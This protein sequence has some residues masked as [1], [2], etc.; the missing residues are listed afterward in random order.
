MSNEITNYIEKFGEYLKEG[1]VY[2]RKAC[3]LYVKAIDVDPSIIDKFKE[4]YDLTDTAW[5][6]FEQVGRGLLHEKLLTDYSLGARKLKML[7]FS[8]QARYSASPIEY[9]TKDNDVLKIQL[10]N[11]TRNQIKQVFADDHVRSIA[12]QRAFIECLKEDNIIPIS[13]APY[14]IKNAKLIVKEKDISFSL[15]QL[16]KIIEDMER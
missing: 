16:K 15:T 10:C 4:K 3:E 6:R 2:I 9:L 13:L 11:L 14:Y 7:S 8:E 12:E 5:I 1:L